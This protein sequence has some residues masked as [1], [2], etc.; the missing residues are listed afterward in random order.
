MKKNFL[1]KNIF[2]L[3][4]KSLTLKK[5]FIVT[6]NNFLKN[7]ENVIKI[8]EEPFSG[9]P[10]VSY[11]LC[12][13]NCSSTKVN[14]DGSGLD[15]AHTGYDKYF[16]KN[17]S[18]MENLSSQDGSKS[19]FYNLINKKYLNNNLD[20]SLKDFRLPFDNKLDNSKYLD[21]FYLKLP[22]ALRFRDKLSMS[23]GKE[24]RPCFLETELIAALFKLKRDEQ[25][26]NKIGKVF[27]R[28]IYEKIL[29]KNIV[30]S[31]KRNIQ[32][33]QT[34]WFKTVLSEWLDDFFLNAQIWNYDYINREN[35]F[36]NYNLFKKGK[37]NNSFFIWKII[38]LEIW[39]KNF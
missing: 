25:F 1:K 9:L 17:L 19:V 10:V 38:N 32:T 15:E 18:L 24:L 3:L 11:Y 30:S 29:S 36:K 37:I 28:N 34:Y 7:L 20:L 12:L 16:N 2:N 27:L 35:F 6:A 13:K 8:N 22:R 26:K 21:M 33:P 39:L 23:L 5:M 14:L 31:K 4:A